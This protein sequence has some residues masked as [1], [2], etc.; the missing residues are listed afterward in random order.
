MLEHG[1]LIIGLKVVVHVKTDRL[2]KVGGNVFLT[3]EDLTLRY[4][5]ARLSVL[6]SGGV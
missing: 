6:N 3:A 4:A 1:K 5:C 2:R